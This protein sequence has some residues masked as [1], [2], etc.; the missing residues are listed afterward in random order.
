MDARGRENRPPRLPSSPRE[1]P[2]TRIETDGRDSLS[3]RIR[4]DIEN[5]IITGKWPPGF[6]IPFER[7]LM[8][9]YGCS[10]M[11]VNRVLSS[12][13]ENGLIE[14][15]RRLGS[16]VASPGT[17]S[18]LLKLP[19]VQ[20]EIVSRRG[21]YRYELLSLARRVATGEDSLRLRGGK[22]VPVIAMTCRHFSDGVPFAVEDRLINT[23][24]VPEASAVDFAVTPPGTWLLTRIPWTESEH[25]IHCINAGKEFA[26][27]LDVD[28]SVACLVVERRTKR[29]DD[30]V[31]HVK[32]VFDGR[33]YQLSGTY[34]FP[35]SS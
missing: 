26:A 14:R 8:D 30:V 25:R 11:T 21:A 4:A 23:A 33:S 5:N 1:P 29:L 19:D 2:L 17:H 18:T 12:L 6:R 22:K 9:S 7:E 16:F 13:A 27:L 31:T 20:A 24:A 10:R 28:E 3:R 34:M 35:P 32:Q 15:R